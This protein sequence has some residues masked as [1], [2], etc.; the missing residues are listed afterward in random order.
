MGRRGYAGS[1]VLSQGASCCI[2]WIE[3]AVMAMLPQWRCTHIHEDVLPYVGEHGVTY[4]QVEPTWCC[5]ARCRR[6]GTAGPGGRL[7]G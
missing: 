3:P 4:E 2:D 7:V 1:M 5:T 6:R